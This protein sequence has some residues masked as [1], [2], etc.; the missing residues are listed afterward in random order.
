MGQWHWSKEPA[1]M[2][3]MSS[4]T[5][6]FYDLISEAPGKA[7]S[8]NTWKVRL[9]LNYKAI[10]YITVWVETCEVEAKAKEIG[11]KPTSEQSDGSPLYTVPMIFDPKTGEVVAD[12]ILIMEYLDSHYP[13]TPKLDAKGT[14]QN[15]FR[16]G[17]FSEVFTLLQFIYPKIQTMLRSEKDRIYAEGRIQ[18]IFGK[19]AP[20][21]S[22]QL[23]IM[24]DRISGLDFEVAALFLCARCVWGAESEEWKEI[25]SWNN[26]RWAKLL[27]LCGKYQAVH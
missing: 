24:G 26:G 6:V 27:D 14:L 12:S 10:P 16:I 5:L 19:T 23:L 25:A 2:S 4:T 18:Q 21:N 20:R 1:T 11:A 22:G 9:A 13:D 15:G 7:F 17:L 8:P 3:S